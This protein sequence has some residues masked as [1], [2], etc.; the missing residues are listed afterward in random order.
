MVYRPWQRAMTDLQCHNH[1]VAQGL[2]ARAHVGHAV[3]YHVAAGAITDGTKETT[4]SAFGGLT[5]EAHACGVQ[6][7]R[8][9]LPLKAG[10]LAP[11]EGK[12]YFALG[13]EIKDG[14]FGDTQQQTTSG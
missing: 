3:D 1:A 13:R 5:Q 11:L 14:V 12:T 6:C 9:G 4:G 10:Q 2:D 8:D 7:S